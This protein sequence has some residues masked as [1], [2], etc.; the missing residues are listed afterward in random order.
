MTS[1]EFKKIFGKVATEFGFERAF[2]GWFINS[3]ETIVVLDLQRSNYSPIY[4]LNVKIYVQGLFGNKYRPEKKLVKTDV[5]NLFTRAPV[6]YEEAFDLDSGM[7]LVDRAE[8]L[9]RLFSEYIQ[10]IAKSASTISGIWKLHKSK[11][12]YLLP[13]VEQELVKLGGE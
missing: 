6:E 2:G 4:Y 1:D 8:V 11:Q 10:P 13:A 7:D 3:S 9:N 12:I 5:G